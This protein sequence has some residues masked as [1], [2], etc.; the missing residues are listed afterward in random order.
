MI[1]FEVYLDEIPLNINR[2]DKKSYLLVYSMESEPHS[3]GGT[4]WSNA[5]FIMYYHLDRS[6]PAPATYFDMNGFL[7]DLVAHPRVDFLDKIKDAPIVWVLSNC[8]AFNEREKYVEQLMKIIKVDSFGRCLRNRNDH[9]QTRMS[10]NVELYSKY[11]FV[12]AIENSN[13]EDYVTEKLVHAVASGSIPIVDYVT[14]KLVHAVASGSIPIV[15]GE[16]YFYLTLK[17][18][19]LFLINF[20]KIN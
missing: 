14:E 19:T 8:G 2:D 1:D 4:T 7:P 6:Y 18:I 5:D 3:S 10:G 13:C 17:I 12:I 20:F 11:K 15:A 16:V 9:T